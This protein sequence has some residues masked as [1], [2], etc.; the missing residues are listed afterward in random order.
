VLEALGSPG[1]FTTDRTIVANFMDVGEHDHWK[2]QGSQPWQ[3]I[4][5]V[6]GVKEK[7]DARI[8]RA[9][10]VLGIPVTRDHSIV[11]LARMLKD[12]GSA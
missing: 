1:A 11:Q 5:A 7:N 2:R 4:A 3:K 9:T 8:A 10:E 12:K 6:P